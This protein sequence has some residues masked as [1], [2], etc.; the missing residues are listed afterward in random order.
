MHLDCKYKF[1]DFSIGSIYACVNNCIRKG[2]SPIITDVSSHRDPSKN[3]LHV[4]GIS[5]RDKDCDFVPRGIRIFF[6]NLEA[7]DIVGAQLREITWEDFEGLSK[8][9]HLNFKG[10][11]LQT[12][13][14]SVFQS[15]PH[16][17][18]IFLSHNPLRHIN[19]KTFS[20]S[21]ELKAIYLTHAKCI[22][23]DATK[24]TEIKK[25]IDQLQIRC[26]PSFEMMQ[27]NIIDSPELRR[28]I[29][30]RIREYSKISR[31]Q[32]GQSKNYGSKT[33]KI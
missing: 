5:I 17:Q 20:N 27:R 29:D 2:D 10:N 32:T 19:L 21:R 22:N 18:T 15:M 28:K 26:P 1:Y 33:T 31:T 13:D 30:E 11:K 16:L 4:K 23:Q 8:L 14:G 24:S 9:K 7:L 3:N 6:P 25:L 12:L